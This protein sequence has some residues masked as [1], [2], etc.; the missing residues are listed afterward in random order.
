MSPT[1]DWMCPRCGGWNGAH[2]SWCQ[3]TTTWAPSSV[4]C[5]PLTSGRSAHAY[6]FTLIVDDG[7][8]YMHYG[9]RTYQVDEFAELAKIV[10]GLKP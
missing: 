8:P 4:P 3:Y 10:E 9:V 2:K 6:R 5:Y 1:G 7:A